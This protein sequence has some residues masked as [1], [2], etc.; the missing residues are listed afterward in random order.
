VTGDMDMS[1]LSCHIGHT[2]N[3]LGDWLFDVIRHWGGC[4]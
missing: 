4:E 2:L 3:S 1:L